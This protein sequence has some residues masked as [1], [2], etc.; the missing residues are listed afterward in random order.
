[1]LR[2][3]LRANK[4]H[5]AAFAHG[6]GKKITRGFELSDRLAEVNDMNTVAGFKDEGLHLGI[7]TS[8]LMSKVDARFQQ[9]FYANTDH[10]FPL[11]KS[12]L[13]RTISRKTRLIYLLL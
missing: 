4:K 6:F 12:S 9:F 7:P 5:F 10:N 3:L 2:L 13:L 8:G 1:L 11:V